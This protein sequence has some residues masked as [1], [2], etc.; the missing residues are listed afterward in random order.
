MPRG[1]RQDLPRHARDR[2]HPWHSAHAGPP[3]RAR[4]LEHAAV[5][6]DRDPPRRRR[7]R[8]R[9]RP[10]PARARRRRGSR[11]R[12]ARQ[13][14][15][16]PGRRAR[17]DH[18]GSSSRP[19]ITGWSPSPARS[20]AATCSLGGRPPGERRAPR[21]AWPPARSGGAGHARPAQ[22]GVLRRSDRRDD[23]LCRQFRQH[24]AQ[25]DPGRRRARGDRPRHPC[26]ARARG[27]RYYAVM[28]RT[29]AD[30]R[31]GDVILYEDSYRNM[32]L[33]INRGNAASMLHATPGRPSGS[34]CPAPGL[35]CAKV[36]S[37]KSVRGA[38]SRP[39]RSSL[40]GR[41]GDH[42]APRMVAVR[43]PRRRRAAKAA[44][45]SAP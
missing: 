10:A 6:A 11:V 23:A 18:R 7:S 34:A 19:G 39:G 40:A 28:A 16:A 43:R 32:S 12:R 15:L 3:G 14:A 20:T 44:P 21:R 29:F 24:R 35:R 2:R 9:R 25:S 31:P 4:T 30:A 45:G 5:H 1:D 38:V 27:E 26:R 42:L 8:S 37:T 36:A 41:S 13:R 22:A 33:A 17:R